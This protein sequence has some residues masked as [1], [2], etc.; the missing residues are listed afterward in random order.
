VLVCA[1]IG[2]GGG[3]GCLPVDLGLFVFAVRGLRLGWRRG[4][5]HEVTFANR[6]NSSK[7]DSSK[8]E[9]KQKNRKAKRKTVQT[10]EEVP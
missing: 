1:R 6:T 8:E 3:R 7:K 4:T 9:E 2:L 10:H 5:T